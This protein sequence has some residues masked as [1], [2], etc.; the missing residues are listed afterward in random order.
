[1]RAQRDAGLTLSL[2]VPPTRLRP[3]FASRH[4]VLKILKDQALRKR[5]ND[6][7]ME[8]SPSARRR[9]AERIRNEA[10]RLQDDH[11]ADR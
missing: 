6:L 2:Y 1:M 5:F 8:I 10:A 11:R 9:F 3:S 4:R 7:G